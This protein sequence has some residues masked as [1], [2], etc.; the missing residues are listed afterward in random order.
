MFGSGGKSSS[1]NVCHSIRGELAL[2]FRM[3]A[4]CS[5]VAATMGAYSPY[6]YRV[7]IRLYQ[8]WSMVRYSID[9]SAL[10]PSVQFKCDQNPV[11][12]PVGKSNSLSE[13]ITIM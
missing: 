4:S 2:S 12:T 9:L 6:L 1:R 8:L 11:M 13:F 3:V 10:T 5:G 7:G